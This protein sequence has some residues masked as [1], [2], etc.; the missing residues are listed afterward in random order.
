MNFVIF[1]SAVSSITEAGVDA[2]VLEE[3]TYAKALHKNLRAASHAGADETG[4]YIG[5]PADNDGAAS[6]T[7]RAPSNP[8]LLAAPASSDEDANVTALMSSSSSRPQAAAE[9]AAARGGWD[10]ATILLNDL[11]KVYPPPL[12]ASGGASAKHAVKGTTYALAVEMLVFLSM[13]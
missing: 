2:D 4:D 3:S 1:P 5:G 11:H 12:F 9:A 8:N 6:T 13:H 10:E 7:L